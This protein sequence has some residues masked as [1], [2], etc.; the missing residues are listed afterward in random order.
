CCSSPPCV[1][2][3]LRKATYSY[4]NIVERKA[5]TINIPSETYVKEID[6]FGIVSGKNKDKFSATGLT[7]VK[8]DLVDAPYVKEFPFALEC[9]LLHTIEIGLHTQF[10]GEIMDIKADESMLD[11]NGS[12]DIEKIKPILFA[13]ESRTYYRV[14]QYLGKAFSIGKEIGKEP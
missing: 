3:S 7:P 9:R 13:P 8:S 6:Y 10:I 11:E 14:G 5:F 1:A 4:G 12:L 2:V